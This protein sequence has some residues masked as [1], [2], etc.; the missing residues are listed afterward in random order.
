MLQIIKIYTNVSYLEAI[1][2][3]F[4]EFFCQKNGMPRQKE[5][6]KIENEHFDKKVMSRKKTVGLGVGITAVTGILI[7]AGMAIHRSQIQ[8]ITIDGKVVGYT[9]SEE[10]AQ[11]VFETAK[12]QVN[13]KNDNTIQWEVTMGLE[14]GKGKKV[15]SKEEL[16]DAIEHR[17]EEV[18]DEQ[19]QLSYIIKIDDYEVIVEDKEAVEEV[20]EKTQ[21]KYTNASN[22]L[23]ELVK[24]KNGKN[25]VPEM[26]VITKSA[27]QQSLVSASREVNTKKEEQVKQGISKEDQ[28]VEVSFV[29]DIVV[30]PIY[31]KQ[32][33]RVTVKEAVEDI[34]KEQEENIMY[35]VKVGDTISEIANENG[36]TV[37]EFLKLNKEITDKDSIMPGDEVTILVPEP[38]LS[39]LVQKEETKKESYHEKTVYIDDDSMYEGKTK[40]IQKG[41]AGTKEVVSLV[42]YKNGQPYTSEVL[43]TTVVKKAVERIVARGT[44][45]RP[46]FIK[47]ISGGTLT[48]NFGQRWGRSHEGVDWAC[49]VGTTIGASSA[50]TVTQA[51]WMNGY[52]Y[53]V[54][55]SHAN[56]MSTRY[57]H[58]S[59]IS[60]SV[61]QSVSQG[62][63]IGYSG[64]TGRSTG[65]HLHFEIRVNGTAV[66]P[67]NYL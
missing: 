10:I 44:K 34:T 49:S 8:E 41:K 38:E 1:M 2:K 25:F 9:K 58:M 6:E 15:S 7:A 14:K 39:V 26:N 28:L 47:P 53:C 24:Q 48:S 51:G 45:V 13:H 67:L 52:G 23:V 21:E 57:G 19:K 36:M 16:Q 35:T 62:E 56:G 12:E 20:L 3:R 65:P 30:E 33:E 22:V 32:E 46:T 60:V 42:T 27:R 64:N 5:Q 50:G 66:N 43:K 17:L 61:G 59:K 63:T 29:E 18:K 37:A 11:Q 40:V 55:I 54:T 31:V 4:R